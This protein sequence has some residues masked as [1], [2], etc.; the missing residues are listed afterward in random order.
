MQRYVVPL[1]CH[2]CGSE[3]SHAVV[4]LGTIIARV[5]CS[6]CGEVVAP[7]PDVLLERYLRDLELRLADK[8]GKMLRHA[9]HRPVDFLFHYLPLGIIRKPGEI[10]REWKLLV[11]TSSTGPSRTPGC[12]EPRPAGVPEETPR[13]P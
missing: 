2:R 12:A 13:K 3:R 11:G 8:P 10:L 7:R 1:Q 5:T 4:Y 6:E 9:R